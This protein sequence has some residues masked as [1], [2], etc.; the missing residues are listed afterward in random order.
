[1]A[2]A[3]RSRVIELAMQGMNDTEI[4]EI[5]HVG[6]KQ[7]SN[8]RK[9]AGIPAS[10]KRR[11]K[12]SSGAWKGHVQI[13]PVKKVLPGYDGNLKCG[14]CLYRTYIA[15]KSICWF[16][17]FTGRRRG[18]PSGNACTEFIEGNPENRGFSF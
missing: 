17:M 9:Q 18:C 16:Y 5:L 8:L 11:R 1:M 15:D 7:I 6:R 4:S 10:R 3:D 12:P 2:K 14:R 13:S